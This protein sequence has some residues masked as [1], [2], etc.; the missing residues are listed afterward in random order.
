[1]TYVVKLIYLFVPLCN[2]MR[3]IYE[4]CTYEYAM[5]TLHMHM[6]CTYAHI[7]TLF[8]PLFVNIS[9]H[10]FEILLIKVNFSVY[11]N[12]FIIDPPTTR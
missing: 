3:V 9:M 10:Y 4:Q 11:S 1:M 8:A 5:H 6:Q 2:F 12:C 7:C